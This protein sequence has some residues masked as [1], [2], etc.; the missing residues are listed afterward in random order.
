MTD[1]PADPWSMTP[2]QAGATLSA[3]SAATR[4][5]PPPTTPTT[6]AEASARLNE[7]HANADWAQKFL[8]GDVAARA[9]FDALTSL[10]ANGTGGYETLIET[11]NAI[12]DPMATTKARYESLFEPLREQGLPETAEQYMRDLDAGIR[13]DRPTAGDAEAC[14]RMLD[15]LSA[16]GE[17][18]QKFFGGDIKA[19]DLFNG[20]T[21]ITAYAAGTDKSVSPNVRALLDKI[22]LR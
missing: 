19:A 11:V 16:D 2:A 17:W 21:R 18:R 12:D 22:G 9:E 10:V 13:T 3:M 5:T 6:G 8:N 1:Q 14:Q 7:L 20:L 15:R 4:G